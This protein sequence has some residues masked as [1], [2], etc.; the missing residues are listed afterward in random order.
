MTSMNNAW[1]QSWLASRS[2]GDLIADRRYA[3]AQASARE[4]DEAAAAELL[5][6]TLELVPNWAPAW[7]AL[8]QIHEK[9]GRADRALD[10]FAR[11]AAL[12]PQD[13]LGARLNLARFGA[14]ATP[15]AASQTYVR[16]LFDQYADHFD[17][18]L[19]QKLH[20]RGPD[21]L[22]E[23]TSRL[24][25][26]SFKNMIDLGC[27]T[28]LGG[29]AFRS[30]VEHLAG[31]DLSPRMVEV[32][33]ATK[34]Y[35]RLECGELEA[36]LDREPAMSADLILAADVLVY[37]G[38]LAPV[39]HAVS[40][41]LEPQGL[42]AFTVQ[43]GA[44]DSYL[45]GADLRFAHGE[46]YVRAATEASGLQIVLLEEASTRRDA[47]T[48]VPGLVVV[49]KALPRPQRSG[50]PGS[51]SPENGLNSASCKKQK[52]ASSFPPVL[53]AGSPRV[54]GCRARINSLFSRMRK[55]VKI[56]C[57]S[58]PQARARR[59]PVFCRRLWIWKS[60][61]TG[62]IFTRSISRP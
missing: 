27:G 24:G 3:Y 46:T 42:F 4:G 50:E 36:F 34:L 33:R 41:V 21:L 2:S 5:E 31:V 15:N 22:A 25:R 16:G 8:A 1:A 62:A 58:R 49:G 59:S 10:A 28:G 37:I 6:Q 53:R 60:L 57:L 47:G 18:H 56:R 12:D 51:N 40:R 39:F 48:D 26:T 45:V 14:A 38:D 17:E 43:R 9:L 32:A 11:A 55:R 52:P 7:F 61:R 30:R 44:E 35:D 20:Y 23:A 19:T 13:E 29:A 54:G